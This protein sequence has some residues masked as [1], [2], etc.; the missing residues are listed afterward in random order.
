MNIPDPFTSFVSNRHHTTSNDFGFSAQWSRPFRSL[1]SRLTAGVDFR[2]IEG[3]DDQDV[4]NAPATPRASHVV[5]KGTQTSVGVFGEVSL[6]P[7][8][9]LEILG[10]L[11]FDEFMDT[12]RAHRDRRGHP[13]ASPTG[14]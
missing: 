11:R 10:N 13:D 6:K 1:L 7:I 2:R 12:D 3:K 14:P 9:T 8:D 4:F 5:G